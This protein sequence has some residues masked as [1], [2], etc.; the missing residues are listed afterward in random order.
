[1]F[2]K[3]AL[4]LSR[5]VTLA[6]RYF[7]RRSPLV[8]LS[9]TATRLIIWPFMFFLVGLTL[10]GRRWDT[11]DDAQP[12]PW[13]AT[14]WGDVGTA[15]RDS[16]VKVGAVNCIKHRELCHSLDVPAYPTL[17]ALNSPGEPQGNAANPSVKILKKNGNS[18]SFDNVMGMI[19]AEFPDVL[20]DA[21]VADAESVLAR[22]LEQGKPVLEKRVESV[23]GGAVRCIL[24][25][26]D[27]AVSV[28]F[29]LR[30]EVFVG[31]ETLSKDRMGERTS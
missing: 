21:V 9:T 7:C 5:Q 18:Y 30:N 27:A 14:Q 6:L 28:R 22:G 19:N 10:S 31:G 3:M 23:G 8:C 1:M 17:V 29:V 11:H 13:R 16:N 26:E 2:P 15:L 24:R 12:A 25:I 20:D 4:N